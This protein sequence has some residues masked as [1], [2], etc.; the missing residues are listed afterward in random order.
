MNGFDFNPKAKT[1]KASVAWMCQALEKSHELLL[2]VVPTELEDP[3]DVAHVV[4]FDFTS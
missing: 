1:R 2:Q 4:C 3:N